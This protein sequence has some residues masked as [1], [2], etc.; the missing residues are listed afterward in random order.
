MSLKRYIR[1]VILAFCLIPL[2][3]IKWGYLLIELGTT[4]C[5]GT[6]TGLN[7]VYLVCYSQ[8]WLPITVAIDLI[9][10]VAGA[11]LIAKTDASILRL[12]LFI[13]LFGVAILLLIGLYNPDLFNFWWI[14][15][16]GVEPV[17]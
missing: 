12:F 7:H 3:I 8:I 17:A 2:A 6:G 15:I 10:I 4:Y 9:I 11:W 5:T 16:A 1:P 14:N 13:I